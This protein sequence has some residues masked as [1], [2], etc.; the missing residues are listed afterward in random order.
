LNIETVH[1][2]VGKDINVFKDGVGCQEFVDYLYR[3]YRGGDSLLDSI[4]EQNDPIFKNYKKVLYN[5]ANYIRPKV[6]VE[7]GVREARSTDMF[8]RVVS[9]TG[10][11]VFSFDPTPIGHPRMG[12]YQ[13]FWEFHPL[14]GEEGY[15]QFGSIIKEIDLLFI[16][17]DPHSKEQMDMWF[18]KY[19]INNVKK[20]GFVVA[21]D[22][23]PQHDVI[24]KGREYPNVWRP[25]RSFGVFSSLLE[26]VETQSNKID[27]AFSV[28]NN[29][30]N[31][32][33]VIKLV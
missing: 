8:T 6:I 11:K 19:W 33:A 7:L 25:V 20:G 1:S 15:A 16:D 23:A 9:T 13:D 2:Y 3:D 31:G 14:M 28:Y 10:G 4:S 22:V 32:F 30:C 5:I 17:T 27:Y 26:F 21:D 18:T 24:L 29:H 12:P